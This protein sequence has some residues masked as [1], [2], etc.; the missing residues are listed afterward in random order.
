M[1][2]KTVIPRGVKNPARVLTEPQKQEVK[3]CQEWIAKTQLKQ[4]HYLL[5]FNIFLR[6]NLGEPGWDYS[7]PKGIADDIIKQFYLAHP[8]KVKEWNRK[9]GVKN[10]H[11]GPKKWSE[12]TLAIRKAKQDA[13]E[14]RRQQKRDF[15]ADLGK[16]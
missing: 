12:V 14:Q 15:L 8:N 7:D 5:E 13:K 10:K 3:Y 1:R 16:R 11:T 9:L 4:G 6:E 2:K